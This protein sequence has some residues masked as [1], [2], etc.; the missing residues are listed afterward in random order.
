MVRI[1]MKRM[2]RRNR[3][4]YRINAIHKGTQRD[5]RVIERLGW[6]NP[7][8]A[9]NEKSVEINAERI[10]HWIGHGAQASDSVLDILKKE[11]V[12]DEAYWQEKRG[13]YIDARKALKLKELEAKKAA[14]A[15]AAK[16][17]AEAKAAEEAAAAEAAAAEEAALKEA[18]AQI[19]AESEAEAP[20][21]DAAPEGDKSDES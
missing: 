6:Y 1:R 10:K 18:E 16:A 17:E 19:A 14:E 5:G 9:E 4:F 21:E 15:A 3:P 12:I 2:G 7:L 13:K 8:A 11:G 20:A